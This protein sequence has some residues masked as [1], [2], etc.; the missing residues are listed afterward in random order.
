[1]EQLVNVLLA[2]DQIHT[3]EQSIVDCGPGLCELKQV[4]WHT[5]PTLSA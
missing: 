2:I 5:C 3:I 4:Y 1:M